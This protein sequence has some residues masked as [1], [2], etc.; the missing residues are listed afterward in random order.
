MGMSDSV[1]LR[2]NVTNNAVKL[3]GIVSVKPLRGSH[4]FWTEFEFDLWHDKHQN[5]AH[6]Q[7]K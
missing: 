3:I 4:C 5:D 2:V 7:E 1:R 6:L